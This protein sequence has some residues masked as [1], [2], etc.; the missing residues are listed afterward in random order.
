MKIRHKTA[1]WCSIPDI[2]HHRIF[3]NTIG[4]KV[5]IMK[6]NHNKMGVAPE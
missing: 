6:Y 1:T 4:S 2:S 3:P 5:L